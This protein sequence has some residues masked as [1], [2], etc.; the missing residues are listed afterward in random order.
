MINSTLGMRYMD[1]TGVFTITG[2]SQNGSG[3]QIDF[4][5][6]SYSPNPGVVSI[7][8]QNVGT[9]YGGGFIQFY[10]GGAQRGFM[11]K[12]GSF[13]WL[14]SISAASYVSTSTRKLKD[15]ICIMTGI[16]NIINQLQP[17]SFDWKFKNNKP[18]TGLIAEDVYKILP[19][20]IHKD[21]ENEIQGLDYNKIIP[22]LIGAI[23]EQQTMIINLQ[24]EIKNIKK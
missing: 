4:T 10:L 17:V 21:S 24:S 23:K 1:D 2:G 13:H 11:Y 3:G 12:D 19:H 14:G 9:A 6:N 20:I 16:L 7:F 15:N 22:Y 18:D 8:A 5:G